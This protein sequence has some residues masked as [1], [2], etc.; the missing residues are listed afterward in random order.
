MLAAA[1]KDGWCAAGIAAPAPFPD[2]EAHLLDS[3]RSGRLSGM[4]W[5]HE[6]RA[7]AATHLADRF[8]WAQSIIALAWPYSPGDSSAARPT[9]PAGRIASYAL[10]SESDSTRPEDY[11]SLLERKCNELIRDLRLSHPALRAKI[12]VD[13]GWAVDRA[14]AERAGIGFLGKNSCLITPHGGSFVLLAS[15]VTSLP[16]PPTAPSRKSCGSC[17][18]CMAACPTGAIRAPGVID[19]RKCISYWTIEHEGPIPEDIRPLL[20]DWIFGCDICQDVCPINMRK[21]LPP[22]HGR[23]GSPAALMDLISL[24]S[25]DSERF[26][27]LFGGSPIERT[28]RERL[29][30]NVIIA[31]GNVGT[32]AALPHLEQHRE[33]ADE[34]GR[35]LIAWAIMAI[36]QRTTDP[37]SLPLH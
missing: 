8:P 34:A 33:H 36:R 4:P 10:L 27:E 13:H 17:T 7:H 25:L 20:G 6:R 5:M 22:M 3:L 37:S 30:R 35:E 28:G 15:I 2:A 21:S 23:E 19:A 12:F 29:L 32:P 14:I 26:M 16:Y 24:L 11:H 1:R 18:T 31:L 9:Y